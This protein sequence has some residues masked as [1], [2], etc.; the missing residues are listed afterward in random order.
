MRKA[1]EPAFLDVFER[2]LRLEGHLITRT[3]LHV[4]AGGSGDPIGTDLP[5]VRDGL[6]RPMIPGASLKGVI[7]SAAEALLR[8]FPRPAKRSECDSKLWACNVVGKNPCVDHDRL[9][10][11]QEE[12]RKKLEPGQ[13]PTHKDLRSIAESAWKESCTVCR[14]FGSM[15]MASRVRFPDLLL[16]G[17]EIP[18]MEIRNGVGIE[19]DKGQ[20]ADGVLYDFEAVPPDTRFR[21]TVLADNYDDFEIGLLLYL[22]D[23]LHRGS[24]ALGGKTTR[25]LGQVSLEWHEMEETSL[26]PGGGTAGNP[27][28]T[29]LERCKHGGGQS[30]KKG[31]EPLPIPD[32]GESDLWRRVAEGLDALGEVDESHIR[33]FGDSSGITKDNLGARLGVESGRQPWKPIISALVEC[34]RL[35]KEGNR[36]V[37]KAKIEQ[38]RADSQDS[39]DLPAWLLPKY[40]DYVGAMDKLW[41]KAET[42]TQVA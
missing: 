39:A 12:M 40:E 41:Q 24:L 1:Q 28:S 6:G 8:H 36:I 27:F 22:F 7:R 35:V 23:E 15:A 19:R 10:E 30:E 32:F 33:A 11:L 31:P 34:G 18:V 16:V 2:R 13:K 21:L 3:G 25:G 26:K 20:A 29:L 17:D 4:G 5:V 42:E 14:L 37:P 9:R 38:E